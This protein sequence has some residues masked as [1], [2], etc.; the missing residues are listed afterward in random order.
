MWY[1]RSFCSGGERKREAECGGKWWG[2]QQELTF[3]ENE[4]LTFSK[5]D[6]I[7]LKLLASLESPL[8][9]NSWCAFVVSLEIVAK[10]A[11]VVVL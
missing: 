1:E 3:G 4:E 10:A 11:K 9:R 7:S 2:R 5:N 8:G 6:I